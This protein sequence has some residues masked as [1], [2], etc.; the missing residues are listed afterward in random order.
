M[1]IFEMMLNFIQLFCQ[2]LFNILAVFKSCNRLTNVDM[3]DFFIS[4]IWFGYGRSSVI[5]VLNVKNV[6]RFS[7]FVLK[8]V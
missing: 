4:T 5:D 7:F 1:L 6:R 3:N 8:N 2:I